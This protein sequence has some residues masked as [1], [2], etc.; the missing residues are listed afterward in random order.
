MEAMLI[1][2]KFAGLL[3]ISLLL[4]AVFIFIVAIGYL[5]IDGYI[6]DRKEEKEWNIKVKEEKLE[7]QKWIE[8]LNPDLKKYNKNCGNFNNNND[9]YCKC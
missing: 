2:C 7:K 9:S 1:F 3:I 4:I 8:E 5:V 6:K